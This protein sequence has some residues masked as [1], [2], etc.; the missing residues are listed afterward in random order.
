MFHSDKERQFAADVAA[1]NYT[2][3]FLPE[4]IALEERILG[5]RYEDRDA[6]W[7]ASGF[8]EKNPN[9]IRIS[10]DVARLAENLMV[11]AAQGESLSPTERE[12]YCGFLYYHLYSCFEERLFQFI[13]SAPNSMRIGPLFREFKREFERAFAHLSAPSPVPAERL[14]TLFFQIRRAFHF[15]FET[16]IGGSMPMARLR[17]AIWESVFTHDMARYQRVLFDKMSDMATL[18]VGPSGSGKD[19]VAEAIGHSQYIPFDAAQMSFALDFR[20]AYFPLHIAA[21]SPTLI[22]SELFGH[23]KG[24]FTGAIGDRPGRL[25]QCPAMGSV[26]LDEIG[27]V[28]TAIQVKLLRVL[29]NRSFSR[30]GESTERRFQGKI[31]AATNQDLQQRIREGRFRPDFY[32]RICSDLI[33]LPSLKERLQVDG[34]ELVRLIRFILTRWVGSDEAHRMEPSMVERVIRCVG[35]DYDWPG[36]VREL[37]Q[38]VK[39][40]LL[41]GH[42]R[43]PNLGNRVQWTSGLMDSGWSA[44]RLLRFY[45]RAVYQSCGNYVEAGRRLGLDRRTVTRYVKPSEKESDT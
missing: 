41:R 39:A 14:F 15:I 37:E 22:E 38:C 11:R 16:L 45:C 30:L 18:I 33:A 44:E 28:D 21:L 34:A 4:R 6:V 27:E 24:S 1:L 26:F 10:R 25:E 42:Y 9:V 29:Q 5:E 43:P 40:M 35:E 17:A 12:D 8:R 3:P 23:R 13:T 31:I 36:N 32:F 7:S 19:L 2:N 20:H